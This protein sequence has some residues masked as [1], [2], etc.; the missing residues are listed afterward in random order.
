MT[1][2]V[3]VIG[4]GVIGLTVALELKK[5]NPN[6]DVTVVATFLPG[7]N[8]IS[9][10]SPF[11]GA[12][13][14]SFA[15]HD[16]IE[17]Q[18]LDTPG[19]HKFLELASDPSSG[20]WLKPNACYFTQKAVNA[21]GGQTEHL[22]P[23]FKEFTGCKEISRLELL[24]GTAYGFEFDGVVISV[25]FYLAYLVQQC[26]ALGIA[27]KRVAEISDIE[28]ARELHHSG[29]LA[30]LVINCGGLMGPRIGGVN[31]FRRNFPVRGQVVLVRNTIPKAISV[32]GFDLPN[33]SL[34]IFPRKEG[35]SIIG[36]SFHSDNYEPG[37]DTRMTR[38]ILERALLYAPQLV[39]PSQGNPSFLDIVKVNVGLRPFRD[40][41][42]RIEVDT[43]YP[44]LIHSYGAGGGGYQGSY[45]FA[46]KVVLLAAQAQA[47]K[48]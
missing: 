26:L 21:V 16:N 25:P 44:W 39:D 31:D 35:G 5:S 38:R 27:V 32:S 19:Y 40:G 48:L 24:P 22:L 6:Y 33:E 12:N 45:G 23:W 30:K 3:L 14:H 2:P 29:Q 34:Y 20:V 47:T 46:E 1:T 13:W 41:G 28:K 7:D 36:G 37:E 10:T 15:T 42:A 17:L 43:Q 4:A 11:A 18:K 9:Y 8:H